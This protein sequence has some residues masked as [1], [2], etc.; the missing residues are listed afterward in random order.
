MCRLKWLR[1]WALALWGASALLGEVYGGLPTGPTGDHPGTFPFRPLTKDFRAPTGYRLR[2]ADQPS[3]LRFVLCP[4]RGGAICWFTP[5]IL[6]WPAAR[7]G[8]DCSLYLSWRGNRWNFG[9]TFEA[10]DIN[11]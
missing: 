2:M 8:N 4:S 6:K 10:L 9:D 3:A 7:T 5:G 11:F 1:L